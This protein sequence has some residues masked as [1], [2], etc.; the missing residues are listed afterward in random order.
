MKTK[1]VLEARWK[2]L[3]FTLLAFLASACCSFS[4]SCS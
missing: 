2:L 1:E 3:T 4:R